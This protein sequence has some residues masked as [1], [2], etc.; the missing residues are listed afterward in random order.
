MQFP[1]NSQTETLKREATQ[2]TSAWMVIIYDDPVNLMN[3]VTLI[4]QKVLG[5]DNAKATDLMLQVHKN[6]KAIV[7]SGDKEKAEF[8]TQQLQTFQLSAALESI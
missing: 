7:W 4:I 3:Y 6:G 1:E 2:T 5:Y 8:Y